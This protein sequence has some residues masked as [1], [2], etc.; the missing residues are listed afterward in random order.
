MK[1]GAPEPPA[2]LS[3]WARTTWRT[4]TQAH[5]FADH[6]IV[7][8]ERALRWWM[9][10]DAASTA[11]AEA[12]GSELQRL[13]R[14]VDAATAALRHWRALKFPVPE[15]V[16]RPGRPSGDAWSAQRKLQRL[17]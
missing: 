1:H 14:R 5:D 7:V 13:T 3:P 4:L 12:T 16:R 15:G 6:E 17:G 2:G 8:F 9:A 10:S 11:A